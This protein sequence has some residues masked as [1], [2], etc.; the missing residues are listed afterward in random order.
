MAKLTRRQFVSTCSV[1]GCAGVTLIGTSSTSASRF[2]WIDEVIELGGKAS[3]DVPGILK[4]IFSQG[5]ETAGKWLEIPGFVP[6]SHAIVNRLTI[7]AI[8]TDGVTYLSEKL[9]VRSANAFCT[10]ISPIIQSDATGLVIEYALGSVVINSRITASDILNDL[11]TWEA[12]AVRNAV[13]DSGKMILD[14][15]QEYGLS[16]VS[17]Q[18]EVLKGFQEEFCR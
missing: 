6:T 4:G 5:S 2:S 15:Y 13:V 14:M 10:V 9:T 17:Q 3:D 8:G 16:T 18:L 1:C 12:D 7:W 11:Q